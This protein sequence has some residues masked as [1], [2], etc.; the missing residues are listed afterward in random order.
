MVDDIFRAANITNPDHYIR[1]IDGRRS[2]LG[3]GS[4][5][6]NYRLLFT[7]A[8]SKYFGAEGE[9]LYMLIGSDFPWRTQP[10]CYLT[11]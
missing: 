7:A 5:S 3:V 8:F 11:P 10:R 1:S 2:I 4:N 9:G 6:E